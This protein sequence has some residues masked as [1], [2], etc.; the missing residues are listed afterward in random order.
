MADRRVVE[1]FNRDDFRPKSAA[2][3]ES[4]KSKIF[5]G[6]MALYSSEQNEIQ[7]PECKLICQLDIG[8]ENAWR[9]RCQ[10]EWVALPDDTIQVSANFPVDP[11]DSL[12]MP[13]GYTKKKQE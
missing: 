10:I 3:D 12:Q 6:R 7:C 13:E 11:R 2:S 5:P 1:T 4:Q 8:L 9:C